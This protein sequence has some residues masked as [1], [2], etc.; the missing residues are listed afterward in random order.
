MT[1]VL[2]DDLGQDAVGIVLQCLGGEPLQS[3]GGGVLLPAAPPAAGAGET[4]IVDAGM[5]HLA[6]HTVA[7]VENLAVV[8]DPG[9]D[10]GAQGD[11]NEAFAALPGSGV[12]F[13][14]GGAVGVIFYIQMQ[15][16]PPL[17]QL[18]QRNVPQRQVAG[19]H[20]GAGADVHHAGDARPHR[21]DI[22]H[23]N[24]ALG[25]QL[26][27]QGHQG[28][29]QNV[30]VRYL[31]DLHA[32]H[33]QQPSVFIRQPGLQVGAADVD[34]DIVHC[35]SLAC[36]ASSSIFWSNCVMKSRAEL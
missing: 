23:R 34:A 18:P 10:A 35:F 6:G 29:R 24:A 12:V 30:R 17:E 21:G 9:A 7:A 33:G 15:S 20:D 8:D 36:R 31:P 2:T 1:V 32:F 26:L 4:L 16:Q 22:L 19:I 14:Q 5:P 28:V 25:C 3:A 11:G 13:R 27:R